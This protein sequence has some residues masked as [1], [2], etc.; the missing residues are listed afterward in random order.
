MPTVATMETCPKPT[1]PAS[2]ET[3][4]NEEVDIRCVLVGPMAKP[5]KGH[6]PPSTPTQLS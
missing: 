6:S 5:G 4:T 3:N 2:T 1:A